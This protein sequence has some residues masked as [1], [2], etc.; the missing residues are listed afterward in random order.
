MLINGLD[1]LIAGRNELQEKINRPSSQRH[2]GNSLLSRIDVW[3]E[4]TIV[5]VKQAARQA[6]Q[7]VLIIINSKQEEIKEQ[8]QALS[9][10]LAQRRETAGVLEGDLARLKDEIK[11]LNK[12]L[13]KL[14]QPPTVELNIDQSEQIAW[15]RLI[16]VGDRSASSLSYQRQSQTK[17]EYFD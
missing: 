13:E 17:S 7:Q 2:S 1:E 16:Y 14:S 8:F 15:D 11:R 6:R 3:Q 10:E 12:A 9:Q 4:E 5:K